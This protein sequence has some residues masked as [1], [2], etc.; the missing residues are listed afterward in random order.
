MNVTIGIRKFQG[1]QIT[2]DAESP[3]ESLSL[4]DVQSTGHV[5]LELMLGGTEVQQKW[6]LKKMS[7]ETMVNTL[8]P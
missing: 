2:L 3:K 4:L 5:T 1:H 7:S 8:T 6:M